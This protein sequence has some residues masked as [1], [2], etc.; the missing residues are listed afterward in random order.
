MRRLHLKLFYLR[1]RHKREPQGVTA[2]TLGVR[3]AT[4][5]HLE[6]GRSMPT[7]PMLFALCE[8]YDVTPTYLLD[9]LRPI[10]PEP[11]DRWSERKTTAGRGEWLEVP[12]GAAIRSA[13]GAWLC[14]VMSGARTYASTEQARRMLCKDT[15]EAKSLADELDRSALEQDEALESLLMQELMSQ[16][17]PRAKKKAASSATTSTRRPSD[18]PAA[19]G[20]RM[21]EGL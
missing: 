19:G 20:E 11:S 16:R 7:L 10:A 6:Q 14:P 13:D 8:H 4:M 18:R 3:P 15:G 17:K 5:S 1:T 9:D 21:A 2:K 12:D